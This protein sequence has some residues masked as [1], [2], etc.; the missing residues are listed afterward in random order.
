MITGAGFAEKTIA[1][2]NAIRRMFRQDADGNVMIVSAHHVISQPAIG[3]IPDV[4]RRQTIGTQ[5]T[6]TVFAHPMP[7]LF[8]SA[9]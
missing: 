4:R 7:S 1:M 5:R 2:A 6:G 9:G 3:V 8:K